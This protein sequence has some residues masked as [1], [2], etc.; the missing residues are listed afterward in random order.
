MC[1]INSICYFCVF[2]INVVLCIKI[3]LILTFKV[4]NEVK[5]YY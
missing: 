2:N 5:K 4:W 3:T 1:I